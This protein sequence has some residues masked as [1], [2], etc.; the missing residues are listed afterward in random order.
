VSPV[1]LDIVVIEDAVVVVIGFLAEEIFVEVFLVVRKDAYDLL[2]YQGVEVVV[3]VVEH[4]LL[5]QP[6]GV[7]ISRAIDVLDYEFRLG[8]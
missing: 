3:D 7:V 2:V 6:I 4:I 1:I 8:L 5:D